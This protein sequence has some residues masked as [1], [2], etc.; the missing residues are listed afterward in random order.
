MVL[1][2]LILEYALHPASMA[3]F[4]V[5]MQRGSGWPVAQPEPLS[6]FQGGGGWAHVICNDPVRERV[7]VTG[8]RTPLSFASLMYLLIPDVCYC[9]RS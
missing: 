7:C 4:G 5:Q 2:I 6:H 1:Y 9:M 3:E 8:L